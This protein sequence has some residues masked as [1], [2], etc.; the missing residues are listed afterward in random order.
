MRVIDSSG[1]LRLRLLEMQT[2][3]VVR[4]TR[5]LPSLDEMSKCVA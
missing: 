3:C 2:D 1:E 5:E 4:F